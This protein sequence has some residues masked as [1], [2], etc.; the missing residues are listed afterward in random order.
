MKELTCTDLD[1]KTIQELENIK[2][3]KQDD[4]CKLNRE[5]HLLISNIL[6]LQEME[7]AERGL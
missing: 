6:Q 1:R 3:E 5:R 7:K 2:K 4:L